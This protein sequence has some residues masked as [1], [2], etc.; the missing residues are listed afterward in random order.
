MTVQLHQAY[1][2]HGQHLAADRDVRTPFVEEAILHGDALDL[3][4][5]PRRIAYQQA[6][7]I[8]QQRGLSPQPLGY[9]RV[10]IE[11]ILRIEGSQPLRIVAGPGGQPRQRKAPRLLRIEGVHRDVPGRPGTRVIGAP[12][13]GYRCRWP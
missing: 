7:E 10:E 1:A 11:G 3:R 13:C 8:A 4:P 2:D 9:G 5:D 12:P 6:L